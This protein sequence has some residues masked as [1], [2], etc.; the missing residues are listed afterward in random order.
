MIEFACPKC[1]EILRVEDARGGC[2]LRCEHCG[3]VCAAPISDEFLQSLPTVT[4][5]AAPTAAPMAYARPGPAQSTGLAV[6]ALVLGIC[7]LIP[8]AGALTA[9]IAVALAVASLT[10]KRPGRGMAIAGFVM[11]VLSL[12]GHV[13]L[14]ISVI[15]MVNRAR[16]AM[17]QAMTQARLNFVGMAIQNYTSFNGQAPP[18]LQTLVSTGDL[19]AGQLAAGPSVVYVAA[20]PSTPGSAIVACLLIPA[21]GDANARH[22]LFADGSVT[23][24]N[25]QEF[26]AALNKPEN[27]AFAAALSQSQRP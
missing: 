6:A 24:M 19:A 14:I 1:N 4:P 7:G 5:T 18:N 25:E 21:G 20:K 2:S 16:P 3:H 12:I 17:Q 15:T 10:T 8:M 9:L 26:Q 23:Q 11:G 27:A 22:V 13:V